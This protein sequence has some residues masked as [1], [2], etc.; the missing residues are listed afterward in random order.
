MFLA[1]LLGG[2]NLSNSISKF[3]FLGGIWLFLAACCSA[4]TDNAL[5]C[6]V[7]A[8]GKDT[9]AKIDHKQKR[10]FV[11]R[12]QVEIEGISRLT[13][14]LHNCLSGHEWDRHWSL[15][16]FSKKELAGYKDEPEIVP[17]HKDDQW[18]KGYLGEYDSATGTL[19]LEP[20]I[21]PKTVRIDGFP[22][23]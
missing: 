4:T 20:A 21:A 9:V 6:A 8:I 23:Q 18:A 5:E 14:K 10:F 15:S 7:S 17:F 22:G 2:G 19:T 13:E 12:T 11:V 16:V 3:A 1:I